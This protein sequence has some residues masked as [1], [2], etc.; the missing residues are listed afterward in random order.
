MVPPS[1]DVPHDDGGSDRR[2]YLRY[3]VQCQCWL[4]SDQ[5]TAYGPTA[6]LALGGVFLID[7]Y[8][9]LA[10]PEFSVTLLA[11]MGVT[12]AGYLGFKFPEKQA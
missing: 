12:S 6:D 8:R 7:V 10:M 4:E 9:T 2:R 11:L 5:A 3:S 1:R